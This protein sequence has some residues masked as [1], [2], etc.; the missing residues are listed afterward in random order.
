MHVCERKEYMYG[1]VDICKWEKKYSYVE[2]LATCIYEYLHVKGECINYDMYGPSYRHYVL[3]CT[4]YTHTHT[5]P[6]FHTFPK[7]S[8][9]MSQREISLFTWALYQSVRAQSHWGVE[10]N[11]LFF[12]H[13]FSLLLYKS[14]KSVIWAGRDVGKSPP[15]SL[16]HSPPCFR[17]NTLLCEPQR[18]VSTNETRWAET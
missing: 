4:I 13:I 5:Y 14:V 6:H 18:C 9:V 12:T 15:C 3:E 11:G 17:V 2:C 16:S 10:H 7:L 8:L 1:S